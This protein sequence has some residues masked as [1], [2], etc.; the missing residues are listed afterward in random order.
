MKP[1]MSKTIPVPLN[2]KFF[3]IV[4]MVDASGDPIPQD[5]PLNK[6]GFWDKPKT[7]SS[8]LCKKYKKNFK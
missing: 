4:P 2:E 3:K 8:T 7:F 1:K 5:P 6:D